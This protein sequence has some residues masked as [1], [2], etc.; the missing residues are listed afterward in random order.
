MLYL[1][2]NNVFFCKIKSLFSPLD[3]GRKE[4][5]VPPKLPPEAASFAVR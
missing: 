4:S 1:L 2:Y 3:M 5:V